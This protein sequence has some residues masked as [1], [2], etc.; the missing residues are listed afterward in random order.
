MPLII[1]KSFS[2]C[3]SLEH[4]LCCFFVTTSVYFTESGPYYLAVGKGTYVNQEQLPDATEWSKLLFSIITIS[5]NKYTAET[6]C[7]I[8]LNLWVGG[9]SPVAMV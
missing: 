5:K 9:D 1:S 7:V 3:P 4:Y 6:P 8:L 2:R